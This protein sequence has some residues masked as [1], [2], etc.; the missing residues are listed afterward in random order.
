MFPLLIT[1]QM[2]LLPESRCVI[3]NYDMSKSGS[4]ASSKLWWGLWLDNDCFLFFILSMALIP[5]HL[6]ISSPFYRTF[7]QKDFGHQIYLKNLRYIKNSIF[8]DGTL[9]G[10]FKNWYID[11]SEE[12]LT[13]SISV[14]RISEQGEMLA[15]A[16]NWSTLHTWYIPPKSWFLKEPNVITSQK[17]AFFIVTAMKMS[18]LTLWYIYSIVRHPDLPSL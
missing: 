17:T 13:S 7:E 3:L 14:T 16:S 15:E 2:E 5:V 12:P 1:K 4:K 18:N 9:C 11:I 8:W 10:S 6:T